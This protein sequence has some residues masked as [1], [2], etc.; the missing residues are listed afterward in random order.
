M[1]VLPEGES[2]VQRCVLLVLPEGESKENKKIQLTFVY[3]KPLEPEFL[4]LNYQRFE[5][6]CADKKRL[7]T[8]Y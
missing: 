3:S 8:N 6:K 2:K 4:T 5:L 1:L 7:M